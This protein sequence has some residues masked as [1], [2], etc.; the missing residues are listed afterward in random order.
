MSKRLVLFL[1]IASVAGVVW[2][3]HAHAAR[4]PME[5]LP[6]LTLWAWQRPEKLTFI[7]S[8][9]TSVAVLAA[10]I[11]LNASDAVVEHRV[12]PVSMPPTTKHIAVFRVEAAPNVALTDG[13]R[14][15]AAH[16]ICEHAAYSQAKAVQ[17]DFDATVSQREFYRAL[18]K[19]IR[20]C[21]AK[22]T[23]LSMTALVS[24]CGGDDWI[25][26][27]PVE[28]AVPMYFRMGA[29][30]DNIRRTLMDVRKL[31]EPLCR[32]S[33]GI[34][35]DEPWP[36]FNYNVRVYAFSPSAWTESEYRDVIERLAR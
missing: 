8:R 3:F 11:R 21:V 4:R 2:A 25:S 16:E 1:A 14:D 31:R 29:D 18:L 22:E 23:P 19:Q 30:Q 34:S 12:Q 28:E 10:T 5:S 6:N 32:I 26:D 24:W 36:K 13:I 33:V 9:S 27:L 7:D 17:I 15:R 35:R 20:G